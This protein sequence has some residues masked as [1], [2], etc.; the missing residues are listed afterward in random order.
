MASN[1]DSP[2]TALP[3]RRDWVDVTVRLATSW[4]GLFT[5]YVAALILALTKFKELNKGLHDAGVPPWLGIALIAAFPV[6]ALVFST[7]PALIDQRRVKRYSE[8]GGAIQTGYFT[9][10]PRE[11]EEGFERP[12]NAHQEILRWIEGTKEPVLYLTGASGTGKSSLLSAWVVP[13]LRL[14]K[15][16]VVQLRGY[17]QDPL[18]RIK[19]EILRPGV[20]WDRAPGN[21]DDLRSLLRRAIQ[22]LGERRLL[23]VVDQF[24][25]FLILADQERQRTFQQFLSEEPI[26]GLTF[27]LVF[28]PE[29][30]GLI[31]DQSWPKLQLDTNRKVISP[32]SENAA[33]EFMRK[34]GLTVNTHLMRRFCTRLLKSN[35]PSV[36][37]VL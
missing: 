1:G 32:F 5:A 29:Y 21:T 27:L 34:S 4:V 2:A 25:E 36:S 8:I 14:G 26:E 31:Q 24:E 23:V 19:D 9:L 12:D 6:L 16:L 28:R 37:S 10:R 18:A 20:I 3:G 17:E 33:Q 11:N 13:K 22:R 35:K 15:Y 7:I 30:E